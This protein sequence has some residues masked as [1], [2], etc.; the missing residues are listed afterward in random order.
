MP[1]LRWN[2]YAII[3]NHAR[4]ALFLDSNLPFYSTTTEHFW[5][6]VEPLN[7]AMRTLTGLNLTTLRLLNVRYDETKN[8]ITRVYL[9]E[10]HDGDTPN[11]GRWVRREYLHAAANAPATL[12]DALREWDT[13][14]PVSWYAQGWFMQTTRALPERLQT[15]GYIVDAPIEQVRTW[16]RSTVLRAHTTRGAVY[17]KQVPPMF[18]HE[19]RLSLWLA[20]RFPGDCPPVLDVDGCQMVMPDYGGTALT[21]IQDEAVWAAALQAHARLQQRLSGYVDELLTLGVPDRRLDWLDAG[22]DVLLADETALRA[23]TN[24]LNDEEIIRLRSLAPRLHEAVTQMRRYRLPDTL[25]HGDFWTGQIIAREGQILFTD[26]SDSAVSNPLFCLPFF[27]AE[28]ENELPIEGV[29]ERLRDVYLRCWA[30][31]EPLERLREAYEIARLLSPLHTAVFYHS[32]VLPRMSAR[33]EMEGML[34]YNLRLLL[35]AV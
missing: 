24:P 9:M 2:E 18:A 29:R 35:K 21:Q 10:C 13:L 12:A 16:E 19:T 27:L 11:A 7:A 34:A 6:T 17:I 26:W 5:Q 4:E 25:E 20:E 32:Y 23:G 1:S 33:W 8:I 3:L 28:I 22:I 30:D 15:R 14:T 31:Y